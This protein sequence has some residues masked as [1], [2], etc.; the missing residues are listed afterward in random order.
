[1]RGPY[2]DQ[3][4]KKEKS[5]TKINQTR[6]EDYESHSTQGQRRRPGGGG[7]GEWGGSGG[8]WPAAVGAL[9]C[10]K[11]FSCV[12]T[13]DRRLYSWGD[14]LSHQLGYEFS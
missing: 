8:A 9:A 6:R 11:G 12:V 4:E 14:G 7:G 2:K 13:A 3:K 5:T 1:M 10:G